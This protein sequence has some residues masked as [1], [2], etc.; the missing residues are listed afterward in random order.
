[1]DILY[2]SR[3]LEA[4]KTSWLNTPTK[5]DRQNVERVILT[6]LVVKGPKKSANIE[7]HAEE[8]GYPR[9][10]QRFFL[11][12][13]IFQNHAVRARVSLWTLAFYILAVFLQSLKIRQ[14]SLDALPAYH[15]VLLWLG[16]TEKQ[17]H[18]RFLPAGFD[19]AI[20]LIG[21]RSFESADTEIEILKD[22][23]SSS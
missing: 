2:F 6:L 17:E 12:W 7:V 10:T 4:S 3:A 20:P 22:L 13:C 9:S 19:L 16:N 8:V 5:I 1:V 15:N 14:E 11:N 18:T 23:L 21:S